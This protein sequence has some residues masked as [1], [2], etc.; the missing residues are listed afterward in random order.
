MVISVFFF[1][2]FLTSCSYIDSKL[3]DY[4][5]YKAKK[6]SS[7]DEVSEKEIDNFFKYIT[8]AVEKKKNL[9]QAVELVD[10]I[11]DASIKSGYLKAY[12]HQFNFYLKYIKIN[13]YAWNVYLNIINIFSLKGDLS[14]LYNLASD[15]K[16][17]SNHK[18]E[19]KL[20]SFITNVNLLYWLESYG[21]LSLNDSYEALIDYLDKYCLVFKEINDIIL[22][23]K[24][25]YFKDSNAQLF[26]YYLST[27][28]DLLTKED[29]ILKNCE[30]SKKIKSNPVYSRILRYFVTAN[31]HLSKREYSNAIMFYRA[32]LNINDNFIEARKGLIEAEFQNTLSL[33][34]MKRKN[35]DLIDLVNDKIWELEEIL[36]NKKASSLVVPFMNEDKFNSSIYALKVAMYSVLY[37]NEKNEVRK[38]VYFD[39]M[40]SSLNE[41]IKYDPTNR[42]A[43]ELYNKFINTK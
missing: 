11:A 36:E 39:K 1:I 6:I 37:E 33:S 7:K 42:L 27:L 14:N 41:S 20:L 29:I 43:K 31:K 26:Y 40:K 34:L 24:Q 12:E 23:E 2:F 8:Y 32:A 10:K 28:N 30:I 18:P 38:K 9:P 19:F 5:F 25:G 13:P 17:K 3:G 15:F 4:Y 35:E 22:L 21:Y 16:N